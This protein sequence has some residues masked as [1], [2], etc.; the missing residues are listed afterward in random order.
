VLSNGGLFYRARDELPKVAVVSLQWIQ[1]CSAGLQPKAALPS[2]ATENTWRRLEGSVVNTAT[3][4]EEPL[5]MS[6][7]RPETT[8]LKRPTG[9][10]KSSGRG[11]AIELTRGQLWKTGEAYLQIMEVWRMLVHY[12]R[13][14]RPE[15]RGMPVRINSKAE[16][17]A[18]L[19]KQQAVLVDGCTFTS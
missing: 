1:S 9:A 6:T 7:A 10:R 18:Y 15:T 14:T 19:R 13:A 2:V 17:Q 12:R 4:D 5:V 11:R 16:I 8:T 3:G